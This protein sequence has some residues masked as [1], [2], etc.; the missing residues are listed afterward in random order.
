MAA[1]LTNAQK[2]D[3]SKMARMAYWR[4]RRVAELR[5]EV[6]ELTEEAYRHNLVARAVG[7]HGLRCCSQDDYADVRG[8][9]HSALG[10]DDQA[11]YWHHRGIGN[12]AR[13]AMAKVRQACTEAGVQLSYA[14]AICQSVNKCALADAS[15][16]QLW[17]IVYT[18]RNH[19]KANQQKR[20]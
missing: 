10:Q 9:C 6:W 4:D 1:P 12:P 7:K 5:G 19:R 8:A 17:R 16:R 15:E 3:L 18:V 2:R 20:I 14:E 11:L 13:V